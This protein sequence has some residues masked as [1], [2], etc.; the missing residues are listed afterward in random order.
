MAKLFFHDT[1]PLFA[2]VWIFYVFFFFSKIGLYILSSGLKAGQR[3][4]KHLG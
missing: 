3:E 2:S 1:S 4:V